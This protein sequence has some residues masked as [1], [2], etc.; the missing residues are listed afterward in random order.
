MLLV[1]SKTSMRP[2][3]LFYFVRRLPNKHIFRENRFIYCRR[4]YL[5]LFVLYKHFTSTEGRRIANLVA[6][7]WIDIVSLYIATIFLRQQR[8]IFGVNS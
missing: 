1:F 7:P 2:E 5:W 6:D 4:I 3:H 8:V